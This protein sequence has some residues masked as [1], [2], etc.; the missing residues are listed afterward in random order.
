MKRM[1]VGF[2]ALATIVLVGSVLGLAFVESDERD[3][4]GAQLDVELPDVHSFEPT[5]EPG[6]ATVNGDRFE[7]VQRAVDVA[8]PGDTVA[9]EGRFDERVTVD[10]PGITLASG[11]GMAVIDGG[12][13]GTVLRIEADEVTVDGVWV[14]NSG[15]DTTAEDAGVW[16]AGANATVVDSRITEITFG[17]WVDDVDDAVLRGNTVVGHPDVFPPAQR[18]NGIHLYRTDGTVVEDNAITAV[19]DGIYFSFATEVLARDNRMW[20]TRFGVHYMYSDDCALVNNVAVGNDVGYAL[21]VSSD[22]EIL[23]NVAVDNRGP[24]GQGILILQIDDARIAGNEVVGN[25]NGFHVDN[26]QRIDLEDNLILRNELGISVTT[27]STL[28][29]VAGNSFVQNDR[30][31]LTPIRAQQHWDGNYWSD[32]SAADL[33]GDGRSE[34]RHQPEG[35]VETLIYEHPEVLVFAESP[36]FDAIRLAESSFPVVESPGVVD[37]RP[38][39]ESDHDWRRYD[40]D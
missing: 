39:V 35:I 12:G 31:V 36:A 14:R 22:L 34:V 20:D 37:D 18:G 29:S 15:F 2:V 24:S 6:V 40:A 33:T 30:Q 26:S 7:S 25:V 10:T 32:A 1:E 3:D 9:L 11:D 23:D 27:G 13:E 19:R 5:D 21:M 28:A 8:D 38:L 16:I 4:P 17:V